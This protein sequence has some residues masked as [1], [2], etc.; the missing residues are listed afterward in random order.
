MPLLRITDMRPDEEIDKAIKGTIDDAKV[1][2]A[3]ME[4]EG[5]FPDTGF[6]IAELRVKHVPSYGNA[7]WGSCDYWAE[8]IV[9]SN[10]FEEWI[11][12]TMTDMAYV[13]IEGVFNREASPKVYEMAP[14]ANGKD[15]PT[16]NI[17]QMY[18][19]DVARVWFEKPFA[20]RPNNQLKIQNKGDNTGV[21]R[22][23]LLGHCLAKRAYLIIR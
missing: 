13:I 8:C 6:G 4:F 20:T 16:V 21:E 7:Y 9:A 14:T 1:E 10:T 11:N 17:E 3:P 12:G 15:L 22:I 23:G 5:Q 19:L 2:W 18:T